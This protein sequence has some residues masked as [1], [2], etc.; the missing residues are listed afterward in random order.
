MPEETWWISLSP[1]GPLIQRIVKRDVELKLWQELVLKK[2]GKHGQNP[3]DALGGEA[4][5]R[6]L[7]NIIRGVQRHGLDQNWR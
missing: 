1:H 7:V 5:T 6:D 2:Q 3:W 4:Y